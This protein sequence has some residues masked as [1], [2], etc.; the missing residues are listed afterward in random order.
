MFDDIMQRGG[1]K[2][3][4]MADLEDVWQMEMEWESEYGRWSGSRNSRAGFKIKGID[5]TWAHQ[6]SRV[7]AGHNFLRILG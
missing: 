7:K 2:G 1:D 4:Q 5:T 6:R 3:G